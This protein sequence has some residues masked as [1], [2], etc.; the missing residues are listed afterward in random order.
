MAEM[1]GRV[2]EISPPRRVARDY[3]WLIPIPQ[4]CFLGN[5]AEFPRIALVREGGQILSLECIIKRFRHFRCRYSVLPSNS[6]GP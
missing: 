3:V 6:H 2:R 4:A 5:N 1:I